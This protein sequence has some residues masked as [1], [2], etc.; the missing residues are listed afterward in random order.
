MAFLSEKDLNKIESDLKDKIKSKLLDGFK[1]RKTLLVVKVDSITIKYNIDE[2]KSDRNNIFI[3]PVY[4]DTKVWVDNNDN[5][6]QG[7]DKIQLRINSV[8]FSFNEEIQN[9]EFVNENDFLLIDIS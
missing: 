3:S 6:S 5:N 1:N 2:S 4:V 8:T 7:N 9:F